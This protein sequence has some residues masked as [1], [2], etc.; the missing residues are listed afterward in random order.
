MEAS[1][2]DRAI[3]ALS[4]SRPAANALVHR[5]CTAVSAISE[6][7]DPSAPGPEDLPVREGI[8]TG[9]H[10]LEAALNGAYG[11]HERRIGLFFLVVAGTSL[12]ADE[13]ARLS[14]EYGHEVR[15]LVGLLAWIVRRSPTLA[16]DAVDVELVP[17][18][19]GQL[20]VDVTHTDRWPT[21]SGVQR[22]VRRTCQELRR[23]GTPFQLMRYRPERR[24]FELFTEAEAE[25][26]F[27]FEPAQRA[28]DLPRQPDLSGWIARAGRAARRAASYVL[29]EV[30]PT[31]ISE[32]L[33]RKLRRVRDASRAGPAEPRRP[34]R[35]PIFLGADIAILEVVLEAERVDAY[36]SLHRQADFRLGM[37]GYD[38]IP[39]YQ[40]E[41]CVISAGFVHY[42]RLLR[43]AERISCISA[44]TRE[45]FTGFLGQIERTNPQPPEVATHLLAGDLV[46]SA[47]LAPPAAG[48]PLV[49]CVGTL[50]NRKNQLGVL[51][52]A[53]LLWK[54]GRRFQLALAGT[55]GLGH[56]RIA[57]AVEEAQRNGM[58]V[59]IHPWPRDAE[60][61]GLYAEC[62]FTVF[63][64]FSEGFGLPIIES[65][66]FGRPCVTSDRGSM[67]ELA[68][69]G[70]CILAD[71]DSP[72]EIARAMDSL[73]GDEALYA[74]LR[75]EIDRRAGRTWAEYAAEVSAFLRAGADPRTG[76]RATRLAASGGA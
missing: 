56:E 39:V 62:R 25:A 8:A 57:S 14:F 30:L 20:L 1:E 67:A 69:D 63:C 48:D 64:S 2:V 46:P 31:S 6:A 70:G 34:R 28:A 18:R 41:Y 71:P 13:L 40:P 45:Q 23:N 65:F 68:A 9:L 7:G 61:A 33:R 58:P 19:G 72:E 22:V 24:A 47:R 27:A 21:I 54:R 66:A 44:F 29:R 38:L 60:L 74:R 5:L 73:L 76:A 52:A 53:T 10:A 49:L 17:V 16:L 26:F 59:R 3:D 36:L 11:E 37:V 75:A 35:V 43:I 32:P 50:D 42:L 55:Y 4:A 51:R 12:D 15:S